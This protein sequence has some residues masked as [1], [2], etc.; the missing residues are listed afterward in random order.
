MLKLTT[1][2]NTLSLYLSNIRVILAL[3]NHRVQVAV[4][5]WGGGWQKCKGQQLH[6]Q[7]EH[8]PKA[9]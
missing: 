6:L 5:L 4:T 8:V 1:R 2:M 7:V 3:N 9:Q